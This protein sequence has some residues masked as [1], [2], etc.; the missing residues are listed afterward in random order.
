MHLGNKLNRSMGSNNQSVAVEH[1]NG[2]FPKFSV[3][4]INIWSLI[5]Q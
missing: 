3:E 4:K 1:L 2:G 5:G